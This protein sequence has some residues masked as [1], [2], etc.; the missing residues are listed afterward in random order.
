MPHHVSA[1][2]FATLLA[3]CASPKPSAPQTGTT[4]QSAGSAETLRFVST[5]GRFVGLADGSLW[6]ID[7]RDADTARSWPAGSRVRVTK[8]RDDEFPYRITDSAGNAAGARHGK[9]LD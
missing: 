1:L 5:D 8:V 4:S 9:R 3:G 7:W 6:N 2:I